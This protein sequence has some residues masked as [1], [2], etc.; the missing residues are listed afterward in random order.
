MKKIV[1]FV[2]LILVTGV[3]FQST[4]A[5]ANS[6]MQLSP[7]VK[8]LKNKEGKQS[9]N[10]LSIDLNNEYTS[11][12]L[13]LPKSYGATAT[14]SALAT[15][16]ST[17]S[18]K[19][20]GAINAAFYHTNNGHP[21]YLLAQN[22]HIVNNGIISVG[23]NHYVS[24]RI[25]FGLTEAGKP[26]IETFKENLTATLPS[27]TVT[28][29]GINRER[30][31]N[32][33]IVYTP[34]HHLNHTGTNQYGVEY[35]VETNQKIG[36]TTF[37][38]QFT[39]QIVK[40][41]PYNSKTKTMIS[42]TQFVLSAN[43]NK[44]DALQALQVGDT[45]SVSF[46]INDPWKNAQFIFGSG[47]QLVKN[48][49][50][51]LTMNE[52]SDRARRIAARSAVAIKSSTNEVH[53]VT[54][55]HGN[56]NTGM[57]LKQFAQYL[58]RQ[59]YDTA[60]NLDGGG[61]TT[62]AYRPHGNST[63]WVANTPTS[64]G[65]QRRVSAILEAV[66]TAPTQ[67]TAMKVDY[68]IPNVG[69]TMLVGAALQPT[70]KSAIDQYYNPLNKLN[71]GFVAE[72]GLLRNNKGSLLATAAGKETVQV[73]YNGT[74]VSSFPVTIVDS[75]STITL[76][77]SKTSANTGEKVQLSYQLLDD[78]GKAI[79]HPQ[80]ALQWTISPELG[81]VVNQVWHVSTKEGASGK[82]TL[83]VGNRSQSIDVKINKKPVITPSTQFKDIGPGFIYKKELDYLV[84]NGIMSGDSKT[85]QFNPHDPLTRAHAVLILSR[86]L[87]LDLNQPIVNEFKDVPRSHPYYREIHAVAAAGIVSGKEGNRFDPNATVTRSQ[88]AKIM[89]N[90]FDLQGTTPAK[91]KDVKDSN[92]D[93]TYIYRLVGSGV[94]NGYEDGTFKGSRSIERIH[95]GK[96]I[97]NALH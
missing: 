23:K 86:V 69:Q 81:K 15:S 46:S 95:F 93:A 32:D 6:T 34:Q 90:A 10:R 39:G 50:V 62:L 42:P 78:S 24:E 52:N 63:L 89:T 94:A 96:M 45:V 47:P 57:S 21:M 18:H 80:S 17:E 49:Q 36:A 61:S 76:K 8:L 55:D 72:N 13:G 11:I 92:W 67:T 38:S 83:T 20:V 56:G 40:V 84:T 22:N 14:T 9:F 4:T 53:F 27:G 66:S 79:N 26:L 19:V 29:D 7:G 3:I 2:V 60:L 25:A 1:S 97:Y 54:V 75:P 91:F 44:A 31:Q 58:V 35:V 85:N 48:N 59:G 43:Q 77:A 16:H 64:N 73:T 12:S 28:V 5:S 30:Q 33:L 87:K 70:V 51:Y 82:I 41:R 65:N 37:G 68:T 74:A 71:V 88:V